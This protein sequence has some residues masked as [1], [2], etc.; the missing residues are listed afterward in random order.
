MHTITGS[1]VIYI[2]KSTQTNVRCEK[3]QYL[4]R[5]DTQLLLK[6]SKSNSNVADSAS[7]PI[8]TQQFG[9]TLQHI[10]EH[11]GGQVIPPVVQQCVQFL[12]QPDGK[13]NPFNY[14]TFIPNFV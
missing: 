11:N 5:H 12:S 4:L 1:F 9:V 3:Y 8:E 6:S 13:N 2:S 14:H 7:P 10:K